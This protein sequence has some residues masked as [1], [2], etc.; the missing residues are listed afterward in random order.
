MECAE[1][2]NCIRDLLAWMAWCLRWWATQR[3]QGSGT[4][5]RLPMP[6]SAPAAGLR[7]T[8]GRCLRCAAA[9][10]LDPPPPPKMTGRR[11]S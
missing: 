5:A 10:A 8:H 11:R 9:A 1:G 7:D 3:E 2:L 6:P 4:A